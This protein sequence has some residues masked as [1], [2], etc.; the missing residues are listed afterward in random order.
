M[1]KAVLKL[2]F[3]YKRGN[4]AIIDIGSNSVRLMI[5]PNFGKNPFPLFNK[6]VNC[7]L[8]EKLF[9]TGK[10]SIRSISKALK[11][12]Q[13]FSIIIKNM[14][15]NHIFP[16]ATAAV[17]NSKNNK[18]FVLPAEKILSTKI[19]ILSKDEEAELAA[20]GLMSNMPIKNGL[21]ADLGGGSVEL[22]LIIKG[23]IKNSVSIDIG[24]LTP[25]S[26][27]EAYDIIKKI[28]WI[29]KSKDLPLYGTGGSFRSL[30]S[31][32]IKYYDYPL[33]L[34]H[35]LTLNVEKA[36]I[37]LDKMSDVKKI[38]PGIPENRM[39]TISNA[40]KI[41][42][43]V[44]LNA[45][46]KKIIISG[47]SIRDGIIS[48]LNP[49]R[50][51]NSNKQSI[52]KSMFENQR[53]S[54]MQNQIKKLF[55]PLLDQL[56]DPSLKKLFKLSCQLLDIAWDKNT[57]LK[58]IIAVNKIL[59]LPLKN[60]LH[61]ERIWI[62]LVISFRYVGL[63]MEKTIPNKIVNLLSIDEK[64]DA[65]TI[66]MGL[67]FCYIFSAGNPKNLETMKFILE[68]ETLVCK[69]NESGKLLFDHNSERRFKAF[70]NSCNLEHKVVN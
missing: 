23:K 40:S 46:P 32:Y 15:V 25:I 9:Q 33:F 45:E 19:R 57:D 27:K 6:R 29:K 7:K 26:E 21:V 55:L 2:N 54:G 70:A 28:K 20:L 34:I 37:L 10:L 4:I 8:G 12:L 67:R 48:K 53:F 68:G 1:S 31:A 35:G 63:K 52:I 62:A 43:N 56:I 65:F 50:S 39:S 30:G 17:R 14:G 60:L 13:R 44:I 58:G 38:F 59:S 69:L 22:I 42:Q 41:M 36:I 61:N 66:G 5:Y 3:D 49:D 24:H 11:A 47:T 18:E 16:I 64:K 51:L